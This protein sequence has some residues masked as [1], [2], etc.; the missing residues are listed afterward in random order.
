MVHVLFAGVTWPDVQVLF[1]AGSDAIFFGQDV[2]LQRIQFEI[3]LTSL[4]IC[5][6]SLAGTRLELL[7]SIQQR[8]FPA[9]RFEVQESSR[10]HS[11]HCS[12]LLAQGHSFNISECHVDL[13]AYIMHQHNS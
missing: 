9:C 8:E 7:R 11:R 2:V 4:T 12:A 5:T 6:I 13:L 10:W 3:C 1:R